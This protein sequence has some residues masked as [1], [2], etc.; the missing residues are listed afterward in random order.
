MKCNSLI[1]M[2][3]L[4]TAA[5]AQTASPGGTQPSTTPGTNAKS[6]CCG[7]MASSDAKQGQGCM[8]QMAN[9]TDGKGMASCCS[10]KNGKSS[11]EAKPMSCMGSE[12]VKGGRGDCGKDKAASCSKNS[13]QASPGAMD[14]GKCCCSGRPRTAIAAE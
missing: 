9:S 6:A 12:N 3:V 5:W 7:K 8:R 1:L 14:S 13:E 11:G 10:G 4:A 2:L